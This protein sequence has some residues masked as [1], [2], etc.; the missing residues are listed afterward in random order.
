MSGRLNVFYES[1]LVGT[2]DERDDGMS[3]EYTREWIESAT[4]FAISA[5]LPRIPALDARKAQF[6]F[7][8][9]LP[10]ANVRTLLCQR[11]GISVGNDFELLKAIG[12]EC[13]GALTL[14]PDGQ[15]PVEADH[16]YE[17]FTEEQLR[18]FIDGVKPLPV[19]DLEERVRLSLAGAQ[20]KLPVFVDDDRIFLPRGNSPSTHILKFPNRHYKHLPANEAWVSALAR[21]LR[22]PVVRTSWRRVGSEGLLLVDRYDRTRAGDTVTR[23]H[24]EDFCQAFG[25]PSIKKYQAEGGPTFQRCFEHVRTMSIA[26]LVDAQSL[27]R[28]HAFNLVA[29]NADGHAKNLSM[30][31]N[32]GWQLAPFYD[33][34]CTRAFDRLDRRFAMTFGSEADPD[35]VRSPQVEAWAND[36]GIRAAMLMDTVVTVARETQEVLKEVAAEAEVQDSPGVAKIAQV[37]GKQAKRLLRELAQRGDRTR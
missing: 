23:L 27:L 35:R 13:A 8:N 5:S 21:K 17:P 15:A 18:A 11:L 3:F 10:E 22:L 1:T 29:G 34:V 26:P 20:D 31:W 19:I 6:F 37:V 7:A 9:L 24:Q 16:D 2:L 30:L 12:G 4:A 28:W 14:L 33:L 36:V 25:L 32:D